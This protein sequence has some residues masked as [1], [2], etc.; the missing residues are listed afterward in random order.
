MLKTLSV[1]QGDDLSV[2]IQLL[3]EGLALPVFGWEFWFTVKAKWSDPDSSALFQKTSAGGIVVFDPLT[4]Y[5]NINAADTKS[6]APGKYF[7]DVQAKSPA[8]NI[9][10]LERGVL[11]IILETTRNS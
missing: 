2:E 9:I 7:F 6:A 11:E 3:K 4:V 8:G 1:T 5:A 10:T